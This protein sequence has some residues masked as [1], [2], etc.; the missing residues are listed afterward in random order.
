M[1]IRNE[2]ES[3]VEVIF[4]LTKAAFKNHPHSNHTEQFIVN[5]LRA[6]NALTIRRNQHPGTGYGRREAGKQSAQRE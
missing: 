1:I 3:D 2:M 5:A 4:E 6:A